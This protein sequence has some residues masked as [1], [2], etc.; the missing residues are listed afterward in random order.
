MLTWQFWVILIWGL[1]NLVVFFKGLYEVKV[2]QNAFG[3][4]RF[5]SIFGVFVWG[6]AVVFGLFWALMAL[7]TLTVGNWF[8][9]LLII[10]LFWLIR[11]LGET[12]YWLNQQF[13]T[14]DRNPIKQLW[15]YSIFQD[16]SIWFVYQIFWQ[17]VSVI[18]GV[19][20]I[21]CAGMWLKTGF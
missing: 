18:A 3:L 2:H 12:I 15:G 14:I 19:C 6:D 7:V 11:S 1:L 21:Y 13:S 9:F 20:A 8:L 16:Q 10:S 4:A 5:L 17:C